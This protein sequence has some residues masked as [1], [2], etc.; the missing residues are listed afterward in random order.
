ME[1]ATSQSGIVSPVTVL[2]ASF[3][4]G[5]FEEFLARDELQYLG[6]ICTFYLLAAGVALV[7]VR[8]YTDLWEV[9]QK[10]IEV[11]QNSL[12][13]LSTRWP[14]AT[15]A[16]KALQHVIERQNPNSSPAPLEQLN[17][18]QKLFFQGFCHDLCR[19]WIPYREAV[20]ANPISTT[21][22]LQNETTELATAEILG[23]LRYPFSLRMDQVSTPLTQFSTSAA[24]AESHLST[25]YDG[26]GNWLL[27]DWGSEM[28]W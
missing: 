22:A 28:L 2:A 13:Q 6:S 4:A 1:R 11:V 14:S 25:Y 19:L 7:S 26:I 23:T 8:P 3:I 9:A 21:D 18:D 12:R 24:E 27:S 10:D 15:G 16:L 17:Y 20:T 5:I